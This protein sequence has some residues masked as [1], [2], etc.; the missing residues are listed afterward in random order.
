M[1]R[2]GGLGDGSV[3]IIIFLKALRTETSPHLVIPRI[4]AA[5]STSPNPQPCEGWPVYRATSTHHEE[6]GVSTKGYASAPPSWAATTAPPAAAHMF[7]IHD[8]IDVSTRFTG[9]TG[10]T[11]FRMRGLAF[12]APPLSTGA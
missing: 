4:A 11:G 9:F 12:T 10:S 1:G 7:V 5:G 2:A 3:H 8:T 6:V